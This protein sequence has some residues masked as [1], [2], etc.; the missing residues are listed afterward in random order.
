MTLP[1]SLRLA[2][3]DLRSGFGGLHVLLACIILG[4]TA[5][6]GVGSLSEAV[7]KGLEQEG[8]PL[9]G[10]DIELALVHRQ[11][12]EAEP[13][14]TLSEDTLLRCRRVFGPDHATTL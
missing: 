11:L 9:L 7:R 1:L 14:R 12:G 2:L 13:A 6:A 4:V 8:Q 5:I 3:R 10:G